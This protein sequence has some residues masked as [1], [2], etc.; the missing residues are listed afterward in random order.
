MTPSDSTDPTTPRDRSPVR[1]MGAGMLLLGGVL[2][3]GL[4]GG[5]AGALVGAFGPLLAVGLF[6]GFAGGTTAVIVRFRDL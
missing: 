2:L 6:L 5:V 1:G 4:I 3:G